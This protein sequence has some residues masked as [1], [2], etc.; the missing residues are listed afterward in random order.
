PSQ[1]QSAEAL[2]STAH[3]TTTPFTHPARCIPLIA[4]LLHRLSLTTAKVDRARHR[5]PC[6]DAVP[7]TSTA[8]VLL[9]SRRTLG[10]SSGMARRQYAL[11]SARPSR[12]T[13]QLLCHQLPF[14]RTDGHWMV[15]AHHV[16]TAAQ[17]SV[18][19]MAA[20]LW[21]EPAGA[22]SDFAAGSFLLH[23]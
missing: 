2:T 12:Q 1:P 9:C 4:A 13:W 8:F 22:E 6:R 3:N 15:C 10:L 20:C 17:H 7:R 18:S 11:I 14:T 5:M 19:R 21:A 16:A 23:A